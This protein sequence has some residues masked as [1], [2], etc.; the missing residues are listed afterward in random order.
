MS[1]LKW[2]THPESYLIAIASTA[3]QPANAATT[4]LGTVALST[5]AAARPYP[6]MRL[7]PSGYGQTSS[8][9]KQ[10]PV[11]AGF[12]H[13]TEQLP[14]QA[15]W[16]APVSRHAITKPRT[17]ISMIEPRC[18]SFRL[19]VRCALPRL[20]KCRLSRWQA[21]PP[22][23]SVPLRRMQRSATVR[24]ALDDDVSTKPVLLAC[25]CDLNG[26]GAVKQNSGKD[27]DAAAAAALEAKM[28]VA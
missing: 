13:G 8:R 20:K 6:S 3:L 10:G 18:C 26:G 12:V 16:M 23:Q 11:A 28:Y 2:L 22:W 9:K 27:D 17:A 1:P 19:Y 25:L 14:A 24:S 21:F 4:N 5:R 15:R 7:I